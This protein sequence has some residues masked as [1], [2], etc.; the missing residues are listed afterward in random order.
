MANLKVFVALS[1]SLLLCAASV[2]TGKTPLAPS[3]HLIERGFLRI[4]AAL[5]RDQALAFAPA[6]AAAVER[7]MQKCARCTRSMANDIREPDCFGCHY[8]SVLPESGQ[9][10][11]QPFML[12]RRLIQTD[13]ALRALVHSP[14]LAGKAAAA[15]GMERIRLY[16]ASA[17]IK[18]PGDGPTIWH[19]DAAPMPLDTDII[20]TLWLALE[21]AEPE[22]GLL[23]F[24]A[25]YARCARKCC[26]RHTAKPPLLPLQV[27]PAWRARPVA[28]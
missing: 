14:V 15:M 18:R 17:F 7:E 19:Q 4:P 5:P 21:D 3:P 13:P 23:R 11:T 9:V 27:S 16:H 12:S 28:A 26:A 2:K 22:C 8:G 20:A 6:V 1:A 25:G 24:V 10:V